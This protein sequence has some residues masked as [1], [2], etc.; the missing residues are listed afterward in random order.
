MTKRQREQAAFGYQLDVDVYDCDEK[1]V[2]D[3]DGLVRWMED[4][5]DKIG[6]AIYD[7]DSMHTQAHLYGDDDS[8]RG[9]T[10]FVPLTTSSFVVH[11]VIASG[12]VHISLFSCR[13]FCSKVVRDA[14][15]THFRPRAG[16]V[17]SSWL[18]R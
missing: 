8:N 13:K 17:N 15:L 11:T 2:S 18:V 16:E 10:A 3:V 5:V 4:V 9:V 6:M 12:S 7:H 14:V 1:A